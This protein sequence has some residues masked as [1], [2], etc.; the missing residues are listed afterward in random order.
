MTPKTEGQRGLAVLVAYFAP[1]AV[2]IA[3]QRV[4]ATIRHLPEWGWDPVVVAPSAVH[5]HTDDASMEALSGVRVVR[6]PNPEPSRWLRR[7]LGR[8]GGARSEV[9][10]G[11]ATVDAAE[12][13]PVSR[14][15]RDAVRHWLYVPDAQLLWI[16]HAARAAAEALRGHDGPAVVFSSS[17]PYSAHFAARRAGRWTETP[18]VAEFRDPWSVSPPQVGRTPAG[19]RLVDRRLEQGLVATAQGLVVTSSGTAERYEEVFGHVMR[20]PAE[21]VRNGYEEVLPDAAPPPSGPMTLLY[22]GTL[23]EASFARPL[24]DALE[25]IWHDDPGA[26]F[27]DVYGPPGKWGEAGG[28]PGAFLRLHGLVPPDEIPGHLVGS[29]ALVLLQPRRE[30]AQYIAGKLYEYLGARRPVV[31]SLP[32]PCEASRLIEDHGELWR[33][34]RPDAD[35]FEGTLRRLLEAHRAGTLQGSRVPEATVAPLSRRAQVRTLARIF[36][37]VSGR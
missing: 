18:W 16:P 13:G 24:L 19:R 33:V 10:G 20:T 34:E 2:G 23:V 6:T 29:S 25:R 31:A 32:W 15:L 4:R 8:G 21:V 35:A 14:V 5:F 27:L 36:D 26:V 17:V 1:P 11:V 28:Q 7:L 22:S 30:H 37:R 12:S 9:P 3:A